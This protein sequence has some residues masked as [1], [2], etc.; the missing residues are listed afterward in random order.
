M[1]IKI[2]V[3]I[4][5]NININ[6]QQKNYNNLEKSHISLQKTTFKEAYD[7]IRSNKL[8]RVNKLVNL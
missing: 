4:N 3:N 1:N 7:K 5:I 8:N 2:T 6:K